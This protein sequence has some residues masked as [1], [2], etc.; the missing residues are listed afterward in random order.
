MYSNVY[1]VLAEC[2]SSWYN[3][4]GWLGVKHQVTY[5]LHIIPDL[6]LFHNQSA[7]N[8]N[9]FGV[10][11][12]RVDIKISDRDINIPV[13]RIQ[14][15]DST[16]IG[17]TGI[18]VNIH[19]FIADIT[20]NR[21]D[22]ESD[23]VECIWLELKSNTNAPS[24][25]YA[26]CIKKPFSLLW[27]VHWLCTADRQ[28]PCC[29]TSCR[30]SFITILWYWFAEA[31]L[32]LGLYYYTAVPNPTDRIIN[33]NYTDNCHTDWPYYTNNSDAFTEVSVSHLSISD[34]CSISCTK[35]LQLPKCKLKTHSI[36]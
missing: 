26:F 27:M 16:A 9:L 13:Y 18:A 33:Q 23:S 12:T 1:C 21:H 3:R 7:L 6:S 34:H 35:S 22:L 19:D 31:T 4:T 28:S 11:E 5:H 24:L 30:H 20:R 36:T 32:L 17:Q 14:W 25:L 8:Y 2:V 29:K 10:T 15:K